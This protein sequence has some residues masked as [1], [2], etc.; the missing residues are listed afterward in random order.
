MNQAQRLNLVTFT[1]TMGLIRADLIRNGLKWNEWC[2]TEDVEAG[3]HINS[4]GYKGVYIEES[5][6]KGLMPFDYASL[7]K[8]RQR[9]TYGNMQVILLNISYFE[10]RLR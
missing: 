3:V 9:W 1:G 10:A 4:K 5:L 6:G 2:I 7:I 8:Q